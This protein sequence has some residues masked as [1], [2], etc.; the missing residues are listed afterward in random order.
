MGI[1]PKDMF[2]KALVMDTWNHSGS[3][4]VSFFCGKGTET[5][6]SKLI[7]SPSPSVNG[8]ENRPFCSTKC[9]SWRN[10]RMGQRL[11]PAPKAQLS[12][13]CLTCR[14]PC[15]V[16]EVL[17]HR[18]KDTTNQIYQNILR[19]PFGSIWETSRWIKSQVLRI[20]I[21]VLPCSLL[22]DFG[23]VTFLPCISGPSDVK[24]RW[25]CQHPLWEC[26]E[27]LTEI[28][29]RGLLAQHCINI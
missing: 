10:L 21:P 15:H 13:L 5:K 1:S 18:G 16:R 11:F 26:S 2:Q 17:G 12:S 14:W 8:R 27:D 29:P 24:Q 25:G 19:R 4:T 20:W 7:K 28:I 22:F 9:V 6:D 3:S 23:K